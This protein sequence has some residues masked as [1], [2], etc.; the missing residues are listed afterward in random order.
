MHLLLV[1]RRLWIFLF[2]SG[3]KIHNMSA[4]HRWSIIQHT[5]TK[6]QKIFKGISSWSKL[7]HSKRYEDD[8][9]RLFLWAFT[10]TPSLFCSVPWSFWKWNHTQDE[11]KNKKR[12]KYNTKLIEF[13][14]YWGV[15]GWIW[16]TFSTHSSKKARL[17]SLSLTN[18]RSS[19][20]RINIWV[21]VNN[22]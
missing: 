4:A 7:K 8:L 10:W 9:Q 3:R 18:E 19:I 6:N 15:L 22:E 14:V 16:Q 1:K 17:A 5:Q 21:L 20:K 12:E 11:L 2:L 13:Q